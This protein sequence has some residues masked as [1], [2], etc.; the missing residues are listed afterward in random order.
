MPDGL[1]QI[2]RWLDELEKRSRPDA[3]ESSEA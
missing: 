3:S 2:E 1:E